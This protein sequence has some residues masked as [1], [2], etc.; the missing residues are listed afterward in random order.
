[1][2]EHREIQIDRAVEIFKNEAEGSFTREES[3]Y[4]G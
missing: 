2:T 3:E 1:M 4:N